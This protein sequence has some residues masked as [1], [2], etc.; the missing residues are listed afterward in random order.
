MSGAVVPF[1][2]EFRAKYFTNIEEGV[3]PVNHGSYGLTPTPVHEKYLQY[4]TENAAYTDKFMKYTIKEIYVNSL[5]T[6][7]EVLQGD[8][9]NFAFVENA[10]SGVNTVLRSFPL[11]KGDKIVIQNTVYGACG[12]TVKFLKNRYDIDFFVVELEYPMTQKE[13]V[14]K[15]EEIFVTEKP[16]LCMFDAITSMPGVVFPYEELVKLCKEHDV[17]SLID[18]A[19]GIGCIP[20][21]LSELKPDFFVS[22]LHK[23]FYVPFGC[24]TLYVD[25][26]HHNSIHTMPVS[27]S[28]LDDSTHLSAEDQKNR[29]IDRFWFYGTKNYASIQVIP[30]AAKFR[31][32]ECGG[33]KAIHD[34]CHGLA[35]QVGELV[36]KKW[37]TYYLEQTSTMVTVEVPIKNFPKLAE[38]WPKI[39]NLVYAKMFE[40]KAYT[41]CSPHNGKLFAR[42]SC[43]I[44]NDLNDFDFASDVLIKTLKEVA[45][46]RYGKSNLIG[47]VSRLVIR[48]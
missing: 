42:F 35:K 5:K 31:A 2:K 34:Y 19:H 30:D 6:V 29:L 18:G 32:E 12:N 10:T 24:A 27:H 9:H 20:F 26:K 17:L 33:E 40:E 7:A 3:Y 16:K 43:Q 4:M 13:V 21:N 15:F 37:G 38:D 46:E 11:E 48:E 36:S 14:A 47:Y 25:R 44:Y 41:P 28:Y 22:N 39:D 45:Q 23:W 1:G 8:Y